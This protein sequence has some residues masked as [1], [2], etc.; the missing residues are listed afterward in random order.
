MNTHI[1]PE[2]ERHKME[3]LNSP[4]AISPKHTYAYTKEQTTLP[5]HLSLRKIHADVLV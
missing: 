1:H 3:Y 5:H 2:I 4:L